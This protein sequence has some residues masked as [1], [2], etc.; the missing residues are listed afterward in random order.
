MLKFVVSIVTT[1]LLT[2]NNYKDYTTL[3]LIL[4][5]SLEYGVRNNSVIS[6][7][8]ARKWRV[9]DMLL[10]N[11]V[12][13]RLTFPWDCFEK[14]KLAYTRAYTVSCMC[15]K[16]WAN[17]TKTAQRS[18]HFERCAVGARTWAVWLCRPSVTSVLIYSSKTLRRGKIFN[19][20]CSSWKD[21]SEFF[22]C[23]IN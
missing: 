11:D 1:R 6:H 2:V 14:K 13:P 21:N 8:S 4:K 20:K 16:T 23:F 5:L 12:R 7:C 9:S 19:K 17:F 18:K 3:Q 22:F 10:A 15:T